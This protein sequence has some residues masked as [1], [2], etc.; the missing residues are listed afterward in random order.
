MLVKDRSGPRAG[1]RPA[2][3]GGSGAGRSGPA[4]TCGPTCTSRRSRT[5]RGGIRG[6]AGRW[7]A[8]PGPGSRPGPATSG[9]RPR[10]GRVA[11]FARASAGR[12]AAPSRARRRWYR[13][14]PSETPRI[15]AVW[16]C[17]WPRCCKTSIVTICS[18]VS[19]AKVVPPSGPWMSRTS[20]KA[21][22]L[23]VDGCSVRRSY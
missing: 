7:A 20:L 15:R 10:P 19:F 4:R 3:T 21:L 17:D 12:S 8:A 18:L 9:R 1:S 5:R 23:P 14:A 11:R 16:H 22:G 2:G 13:T 6:G